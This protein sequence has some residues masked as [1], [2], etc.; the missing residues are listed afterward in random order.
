M[1]KKAIINQIRALYADI[2]EPKQITMSEFDFAKLF[3]DAD[4]VQMI[5]N[6]PRQRRAII[7]D[8]A[9]TYFKKGTGKALLD[10]L[11]KEACIELLYK[12]SKVRK[13]PT[14]FEI[15]KNF[16]SE[17]FQYYEKVLNFLKM[18]QRKRKTIYEI[19]QLYQ[20]GD[21][22]HRRQIKQIAISF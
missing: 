12:K 22:R 9:D 4:K 6:L 7:F 21:Y 8:V 10:L 13:S 14:A 5:F 20:Q 17:N 19:A 2:S 16:P 15:D 3:P 18:P 1:Y 11:I